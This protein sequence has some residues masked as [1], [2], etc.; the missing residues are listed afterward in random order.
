[1]LPLPLSGALFRVQGEGRGSDHFPATW[2]FYSSTPPLFT[3]FLY[4]RHGAVLP[5][6]VAAT[7]KQQG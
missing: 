1:M 5:R 4:P 7:W 3:P 2:G 6:E